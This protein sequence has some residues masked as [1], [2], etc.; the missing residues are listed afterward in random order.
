MFKE[1][2]DLKNACESII[3]KSTKIKILAK[4]LISLIDKIKSETTQEDAVE[5]TL[6]VRK[7][8]AA[9]F[10]LNSDIEDNYKTLQKISGS[11]RK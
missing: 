7:E 11:L 2:G 6:A 5:K 1:L 10:V 8:L 4:N 3:E 9:M